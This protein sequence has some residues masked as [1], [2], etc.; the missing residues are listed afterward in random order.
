MLAVVR[1]HGP[2]GIHATSGKHGAVCSWVVLLASVVTV[3][4]SCS[5]FNMLVYMRKIDMQGKA[6]VHNDGAG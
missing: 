1:K 3:R 4:R 2:N 5:H 6:N